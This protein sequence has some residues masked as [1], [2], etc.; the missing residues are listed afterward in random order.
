M[1]TIVIII[2]L[3]VI[4]SCSSYNHGYQ[5]Y[6]QEGHSPD[7]L[8]NGEDCHYRHHHQHQH[9][10][11]PPSPLSSSLSSSLSSYSAITYMNAKILVRFTPR[12]NCMVANI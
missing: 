11:W 3:I 9:G 2:A 7:H 8:N 12:H 6:Y 4:I 10:H 1:M 5:T